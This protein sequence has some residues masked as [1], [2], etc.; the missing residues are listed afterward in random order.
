MAVLKQENRLISIHTNLGEDAL[1]LQ[2]FSGVEGISRLFNFNLDLISEQAS[3][4]MDQVV[5]QRAAIRVALGD[6]KSYR[7]IHGFISRFSQGNKEHELY[8][9]RAQLVPWLWFLTRRA[10][11]RI[12]QNLSV[13]DIIQKIFSELGF[14]DFR[15]AVQGSFEP[16]E[17][18]VQYRETDFNFVSRLMEQYGIFYFFEH[19]KTKHMLVLANSPGG[20]TQ[21]PVE[22]KFPVHRQSSTI[23][24]SDYVS[25]FE[26]QYEVRSGKYTMS[27][28]FFETPTTSLEVNLPSTVKLPN[29]GGFEIYDYP[30]E[31]EKK[32][33]GEKLV[34][35]R[36]EEEEALH[37]VVSGAGVCRVFT[38]GHKF[39]L[40]DHYRSD[41]NTNYVLTEVHHTATV[42]HTYLGEDEEGSESYSNFFSCIP[43]AVPYRPPRVTPK[44]VIQGTQTAVVVG[45]KGEEI[46]VDKYSRIKVQFHWDRE[47]KFDEKS[48]CWIRV[49]SPWAG[50]QWGAIHIPRIG[51][52]VIVEFEEGDPDHPIVV[53]SVYNAANMP[54]YALPGE[55]TKSGIKSMSTKGGGG[56]NEFRFEDKKGSEQLFISAERNQDVRTK[57]D[58][59]EFVGN[60]NHLIVKKDDFEKIEGEKHF[61]VVKDQ[62][63][64]FGKD[65]HSHVTGDQNEKVDKTAS[66]KV[67]M[68]LQQKVGKNYAVDSGMEIHLKAGMNVMIESGMQLTLKAGGSFINIGPAGIAISGAPMVLVNSG[69][70]AGSGSGSSPQPPKDPKAAKEAD[71]AKAGQVETTPPPP[72]PPQPQKYSAKALMIKDAAKSGTPFC[73]V[74]EFCQ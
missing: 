68:D 70:A 29:I 28:Y 43:L 13:L 9:Y 1:L 23:P 40:K 65:L 58:K 50:K 16:L 71:K 24:D 2:S 44:P 62:F 36:M 46:W 49:A 59:L 14:S 61:E 32:A 7:Y 10:G 66:L 22:S 41:L 57:N 27:D 3:I 17:Y 20:H 73:H 31:Y 48:S 55:Q 74:C 8:R 15:L 30:G 34:K 42:G 5:G 63:E 53:G 26:V 4:K 35:V 69:G 37:Q 11:S 54:G 6:H 25:A 67:G 19:D 33:Q 51:Q 47:G 18:C 60:E 38:A 64:K 56:F 52:E 21:C 39:A 72:R 12:F 45:K